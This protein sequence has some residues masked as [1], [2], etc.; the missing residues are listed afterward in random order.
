MRRRD[1]VRIGALALLARAGGLGAASAHPL[2]A[3]RDAKEPIEMAACIGVHVQRLESRVE[4][5]GVLARAGL[6][7]VKPAD[8]FKPLAGVAAPGVRF[9]AAATA[10]GRYR[11]A[12]CEAQVATWSEADVE[13]LMRLL[14]RA[15]LANARL[16]ELKHAYKDVLAKSRER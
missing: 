3:C 16:I 1:R 11:D 12:E 5:V 6:I 7:A 10:W 4:R 9:D 15:N 2:D 8:D 14:C 13:P